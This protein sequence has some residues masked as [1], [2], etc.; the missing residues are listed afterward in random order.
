VKEVFMSIIAKSSYPHI[1]WLDF[2]DFCTVSKIPD[3]FC[4]I[5]KIDM[6]FIATNVELESIVENPDRDLN[7]YEF[8]EIVLRL[9]IEKFK[10]SG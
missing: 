8:Y 1:S 7:R 4:T 3:K 2:T 6:A 5:A 10:K 9:G